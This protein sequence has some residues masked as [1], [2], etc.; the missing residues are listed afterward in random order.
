[1]PE[2]LTAHHIILYYN[3]Q[4]N[5]FIFSEKSLI[6]KFRVTDLGLIVLSDFKYL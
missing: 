4:Q 6:F 2:L 5:C 1:M 3:L